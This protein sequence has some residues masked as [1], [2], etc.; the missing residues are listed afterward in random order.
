MLLS[1]L[2]R[3]KGGLAVLLVVFS[4]IIFFT[5]NSI[6]RGRLITKLEKTYDKR[7]HDEKMYHSYSQLTRLYIK[8]YQ[9][10]S[11]KKDLDTIEFYYRKADSTVKVIN[12]KT[13]IIRSIKEKLGI[14][15]K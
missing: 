9:R 4:L 6:E 13:N 15:N 12:T 11:S 3:S 7:S 14:K 1:W 5:I 8:S 10:D 2:R